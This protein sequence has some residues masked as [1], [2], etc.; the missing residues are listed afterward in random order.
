[1]EECFECTNPYN[2]LTKTC[3]LPQFEESEPDPGH[4]RAHS[5]Y[6]QQQRD[7]REDVDGQVCQDEVDGRNQWS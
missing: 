1:M 6:V 7:V 2:T 5:L 3:T 4:D